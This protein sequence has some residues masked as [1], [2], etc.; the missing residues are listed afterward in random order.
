M[1]YC[2]AFSID[3]AEYWKTMCQEFVQATREYMPEY[4]KRLKNHLI[5]HLVDNIIEFG[6]TQCYITERLVKQYIQFN[7]L[8]YFRYEAFN[9]LVRTQNIFGNR[10]SPSKDIAHNF[11]V[12]QQLHFLCSGGIFNENQQ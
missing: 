2:V 4:S 10:H 7:Y 1:A 11:A 9:G 3:D 8:I 5:L 6:P 12:M